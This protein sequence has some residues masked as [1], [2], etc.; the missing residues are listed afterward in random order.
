M[1]KKTI[2]IDQLREH[3][4]TSLKISTD[5]PDMRQGKILLLEAILH[6]TGNYNGYRFLQQEEVPK[7]QLPGIR[8]DSDSDGITELNPFFNTDPTRV[9]YY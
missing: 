2:K 7:G 3:V 9:R 5:T 8:I 1:A 4:N 6:L